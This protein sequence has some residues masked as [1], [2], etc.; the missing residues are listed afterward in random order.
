[1]TYELFIGDRTFSSWSM[2]GWLLLEKFGIEH[3]T[4]VV[5]LYSGTMAA[6]MA[7][8]PMARTV[9]AMRTP[10]GD[11]LTDS[12]SIAETLVERHADKGLY[13]SALP[14][15]VFAR[16]FMAEMHSGFGTLRDEC[17]N[18]LDNT[19]VGFTPSDAVLKDVA[20]LEEWVAFAGSLRAEGDWLLGAYS[21]VDAFF[22]PYACRLV[23]YGLPMSERM[24][25][26]VH[27][28]LDDNA[29]RRWRAMGQ[30]VV[31]DPFP[32]Q[33]LFTRA[34]WPG[35]RI[36]ARAVDGGPSENAQ[37]PYSGKPVTHFMAIEDR[38]FGFCNT[39]CRDKTAAD[40]AAWPA[41]MAL[42]EQR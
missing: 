25:A 26:Y 15:R 22:A 14:A 10:E 41:F 30:T 6:D 33:L 42:Y 8:L 38:I 3:K 28:H 11:V 27:K 39:F 19:W 5:G 12:L 36:A 7:A 4:T 16:N 35:E 31:Y 37:C 17:P 2:R 21:A 29:F 23:T 24:Q 1:M 9:P 18:N 13:P 34:D 20:R 32:Y 40:P